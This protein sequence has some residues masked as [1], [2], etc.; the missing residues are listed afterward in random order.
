VQSSPK[1]T[2]LKDLDTSMSATNIREV[3]ASVNLVWVLVAMFILNTLNSLDRVLLG[4]IQ[5]LIKIDLGLSDFQLGLLGGP[6]FAILYGV[7]AFPIARAADR[8]NRINIIGLVLVFWSTM[9][10]LC[11]TAT[12]FF[13]ILLARAGVS[14]GEAGCAPAAH[15]L[16]SDY[17]GP[18]RRTFA[19]AIYTSGS[20]AGSLMAAIAGG[21][22]SEHF[23][24]RQTF[25]FFGVVGILFAILFR[26]T[27]REPPRATEWAPPPRFVTAIGLLLRKRTYAMVVVSGSFASLAAN[28]LALYLVSFLIRSHGMSVSAAGLVMGLAV[29]AIGFF[30]IIAAGWIV[31]RT[32]R[33]FPQ[34]RTWLPAGG[35]VWCGVFY[36]AAFNVDST[37]VA[38]ALIFMANLGANMF[39][40]AVYTVAQDLSPPAMRATSAALMISIL[41][42]LGAGLGPPLI[43]FLSDMVSGLFMQASGSSALACEAGMTG[44]C[45]E[46]SARGLSLSLTVAAAILIIAGLIYSQSGRTIEHDLLTAR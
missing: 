8:H 22:I 29:G 12:S 2:P 40:P 46:A 9:T 39:I 43:G 37:A 20:A 11:G 35:M 21:W 45:K 31:D 14:I 4:V 36:M 15:S 38:I 32:K 13:Q 5:E 26:L 41:A 28:A 18:D 1:A 10:A 16:I 3:P 7:M 34:M 6:A 23:G 42:V 17:F 44:I 27:L 19:I 33:R 25:V 30:S 24:W